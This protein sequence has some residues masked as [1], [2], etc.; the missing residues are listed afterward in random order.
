[1]YTSPS[2][3]DGRSN[4]TFTPSID[5]H[6]FSNDYRNNYY[7]PD[8]ADFDDIYNDRDDN[9]RSNYNSDRSIDHIKAQY[10][11]PIDVRHKNYRE[12]SIYSRD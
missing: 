12:A 5:N 4:R 7:S 8:L 10:Y 3:K 1:L 9:N 11:R 6:D 2:V